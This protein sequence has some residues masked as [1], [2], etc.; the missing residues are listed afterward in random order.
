MG[1]GVGAGFVSLH[2]YLAGQKLEAGHTQLVR[3][4]KCLPVAENRTRK[5]HTEY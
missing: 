5:I 4:M 1:G 3:Y 2:G